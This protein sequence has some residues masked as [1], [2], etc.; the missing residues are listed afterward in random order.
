MPQ[1]VAGLIKILIFIL[2]GLLFR[3]TGILKKQESEGLK[4]LI[5]KTAIP[6]VLFLSFSRLEIGMSLI[7]VII[8]VLLMNLIMF[9][10]GIL[11]FRLSP[12]KDRILPIS[13]GTINL[14][15]LGI[16]LYEAFF[17]AENLHHYT[18]LGIGNE[19]FIWFVFQFLA[20]W[21]LNRQSGH[22]KSAAAVLANPIVWGMS[23]GVVFSILGIDISVSRNI[24]VQGIYQVI[25]G[26]SKL[27][28]PLVLMYI[29]FNLI[30][31]PAHISRSIKLI[32]VRM[33]VML[34]IGL[35][36]KYTVMDR[37]LGTSVYNNAAWF[38]LMILPAIFSVPLILSDQLEDEEFTGLNNTIVIHS[39]ITIIVF[40]VYVFII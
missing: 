13:L 37:L 6:A 4:K 24:A 36:L 33:A 32:A 40:S 17:G 39:I 35:V 22:R 25:T 2:L 3:K 12:L 23:I 30:I 19:I 38:L 5:L 27:T 8:I 14:V 29:G 26:L 11:V 34:A 21:F 16:P 20:Q 1:S 31:T 18:I 9:F 15:L 28:T 10:T 7:P